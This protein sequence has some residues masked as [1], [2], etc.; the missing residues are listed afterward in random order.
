MWNVCS[1]RLVDVGWISQ[2]VLANN[3]DLKKAFGTDN[4]VEICKIILDKGEMQVWNRHTI[5]RVSQSVSRSVFGAWHYPLSWKWLQTVSS[6]LSSQRCLAALSTWIS[7]LWFSVPNFFF[8][9][10]WCISRVICTWSQSRACFQFMK[11]T[12]II[13]ITSIREPVPCAKNWS[14]VSSLS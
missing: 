3:V 1:E 6:T 10:R 13:L 14:I 11:K 8:P 2:G 5:K 4:Q 9:F 12:K 7:R